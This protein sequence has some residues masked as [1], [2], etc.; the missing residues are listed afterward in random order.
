MD[1]LFEAFLPTLRLLFTSRNEPML[2]G[3]YTTT[4]FL[5]KS[6]YRASDEFFSRNDV[7][8]FCSVRCLT[9]RRRMSVWVEF[10]EDKII[11]TKTRS[12]RD[13]CN[14]RFIE[15]S[16]KNKSQVTQFY[17]KPYMLCLN[18]KFSVKHL[19]SIYL[20]NNFIFSRYPESTNT[21]LFYGRRYLCQF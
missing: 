20:G 21:K 17:I 7:F 14:H 10:Y 18:R 3:H 11:T 19:L 9:Q 15:I 13:F 4:E 1:D 6:D 2:S 12:K 16:P 5:F 8:H